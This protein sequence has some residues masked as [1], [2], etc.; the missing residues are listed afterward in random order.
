LVFNLDG[1]CIA[2]TALTVKKSVTDYKPTENKLVGYNK[3]TFAVLVGNSVKV[4]GTKVFASLPCH[5]KYMVKERI[6]CD[7]GV[8]KAKL[9][10][11]SSV[12]EKFVVEI[13]ALF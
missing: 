6:K 8:V 5:D 4:Y 13:V 1:G 7:S 11:K 10:L 3:P 9:V 2:E 12:T